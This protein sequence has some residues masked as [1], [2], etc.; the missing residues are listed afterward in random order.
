MT[1]VHVHYTADAK[2]PQ[3]ILPSSYDTGFV[4]V[5]TEVKGG[6]AIIPATWSAN[7][8]GFTENLCGV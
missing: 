5:I 3:F 7:Y 1:N 2:T 8:P 4:N 6:L